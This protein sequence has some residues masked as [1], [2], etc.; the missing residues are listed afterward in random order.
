MALEMQGDLQY[1]NGK[2]Q[3]VMV[4]RECHLLYV[5]RR[6]FLHCTSKCAYCP[7]YMIFTCARYAYL[8][9]PKI[10]PESYGA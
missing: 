6:I 3:K 9:P 7:E 4:V 5:Y 8:Y 1:M 10:M 2:G